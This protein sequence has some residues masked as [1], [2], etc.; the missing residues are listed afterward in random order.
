MNG[1]VKK[2]Q[3]I[4]V[5]FNLLVS[6]TW[7]LEKKGKQRIHY[8]E[9]KLE[10]GGKIVIYNAL[11]VPSPF[12]SKFL[13]YLM[14][15]AQ[16]NDWPKELVIGSL[17]QIAKDLGIRDDKKRIER[18]KKSLKILVNTRIEFEDCFI[19]TGV[20]AHFE[21]KVKVV[22]IGILSDYSLSPTRGR[23]NPL[24]VKV[25]FNENFLTLCKHSL[26]YKLVPYI[27]KGLRDTSYALYKWAYRWYN[28]ETGNGER[29]IGKG[30]SLVE[31][32]KN[33]LNSLARYK[34][35]SE[36]LRRLKNAIKQINE[37][38]EVPFMLELKKDANDTYKIEIKEKKKIL[39]KKE[40]P[41][42]NL[43]SF[44]RRIVVGIL[45]QKEKVKNPFAL[46]RSMS[47]EDIKKLLRDVFIID[48]SKENF[49]FY[50]S[51]FEDEAEKL[52][53]LN[54]IITKEEKEE[55]LLLASY[56]YN[57]KKGKYLHGLLEG[58]EPDWESRMKSA[59]EMLEAEKALRVA[60][61]GR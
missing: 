13:D 20:L 39:L 43:S 15:K 33:E 30:Y 18:L 24:K 57:F 35:P 58:F 38:E 60:Y 10:D 4:K 37:H 34:Y 3:R 19:D 27:P 12:D 54:S 22:D 7:V 6:G 9:K 23:G 25:V 48:V 49:N 45:Y 52:K 31:W 17:R 61:D 56:S 1:N 41:F 29:W 5:D 47:W 53:F 32:Y 40:A 42:D 14:L 59:L 55:K 36:V 8:F 28:S 11:D 50:I 44:L 26:G 51:L 16:E 46:V 2:N 21:G